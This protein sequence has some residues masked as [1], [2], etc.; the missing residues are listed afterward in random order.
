MAAQGRPPQ[1]RDAMNHGRSIGARPFVRFKRRVHKL[2]SIQDADAFQPIDVAHEDGEHV[3]LDGVQVVHGHRLNYTLKHVW[4]VTVRA[5][6][7][8]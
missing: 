2:G 6:T 8:Y 1:R 5:L 4:Q 7:R 3:V